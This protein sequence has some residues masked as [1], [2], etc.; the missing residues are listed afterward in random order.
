MNPTPISI[1]GADG[2][3]VR[4]SAPARCAEAP[5][6]APACTSTLSRAAVDQLVQ[7]ELDAFVASLEQAGAE[8]RLPYQVRRLLAGLHRHLFDPDLNVAFLREACGLTNHNIS[9]Y[10]KRAV[11]MSLPAYIEAGRLEAAKR[12]LRLPGLGVLEIAWMVGYTYVESFN[13]AFRRR[14]GLTPNQYRRGQGQSEP[15]KTNG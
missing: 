13:R 12:L 14:E 4:W 10:F 2:L 6:P 7:A 8:A 1:R 5:V 11:G 15:V 3:P 9:S